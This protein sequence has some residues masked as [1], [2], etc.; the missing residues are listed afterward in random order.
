MRAINQAEL[1][2]A[3]VRN[4][5]PTLA[6]LKPASLFTFPG[7]FVS[8]GAVSEKGRAEQ[9]RKA[10]SNIVQLCAEQLESVG[11]YLRVLVWRPCGALIYAYRRDMLRSHL[12]DERA[13]VPLRSEGY[14]VDD[15]EACL[16]QLAQR[17]AGAGKRTIA[18]EG[19]KKRAPLD[20]GTA[21]EAHG[22]PCTN[23][24]C[25]REFPH[26]LGY[27]LGYPYADVAEFIRQH[28]EN[29]LEFG[30]WKIYTERERALETFARYK[31]CTRSMM[32]AYRRRGRL[33]GLAARVR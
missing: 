11:V 29:Y 21:P 20:G 16:D 15:L 31:R 5:A 12:D 1:E 19:A 32:R 24:T 22:C 28:G 6:A 27:F 33:E 30:M 23:E 17:I 10:L 26:E 7:V 18:N 2:Q 9:N 13:A 14:R 8:D 3:I 25:R 4:C